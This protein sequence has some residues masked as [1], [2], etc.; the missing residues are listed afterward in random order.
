MSQLLPLR[1]LLCVSNQPAPHPTP[2]VGRKDVLF[3]SAL[4]GIQGC[5]MIVK[6][7]FQ[8]LQ[9]I[10]KNL[11][12]MSGSPGPNSSSCLS[13]FAPEITSLQCLSCGTPVVLQLSSWAVRS[14]CPGPHRVDPTSWSL[15]WGLLG[16]SPEPLDHV[17]MMAIG[18][19]AS[20]WWPSGL[21]TVGCPSLCVGL[22]ESRHLLSPTCVHQASLFLPQ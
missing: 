3:S 21:G 12:S 22:V 4:G 19:R 1:E 20:R 2:P 18:R 13:S 7:N 15:A 9:V 5:S 17:R 6:K 14:V 10:V 8:R 11:S 16:P